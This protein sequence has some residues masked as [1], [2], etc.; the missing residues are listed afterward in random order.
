MELLGNVFLRQKL[1]HVNAITET[2]VTELACTQSHVPFCRIYYVALSVVHV[3]MESNAAQAATA[4]A[5]H[6]DFRYT[7]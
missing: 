6:S 1:K 5:L 7:A 2:S 4:N 3:M